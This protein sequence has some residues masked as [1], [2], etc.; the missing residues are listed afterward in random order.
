MTSPRSYIQGD[1]PRTDFKN[2]EWPDSDP[3]IYHYDGGVDKD[4]DGYHT[5]AA[6]PDGAHLEGEV[7]VDDTDP[8]LY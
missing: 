8:N 5:A 6:G 1:D 4:G 2:P 7:D 3:R